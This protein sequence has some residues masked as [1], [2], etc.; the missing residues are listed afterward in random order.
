MAD[1]L[2][3]AIVVRE[4]RQTTLLPRRS[5]RAETEQFKAT[6][7]R[8]KA[9]GHWQCWICGRTD[10]LQVHH[11]LIQRA[12]WPALDPEKV[13]TVTEIIDLYGY[14]KMLTGVPIDNPDVIRLMC[15]LCPAHHAGDQSDGAANGVH[16]IEF[17]AW[18]MQRLVRPGMDLI[19][20]D[21]ESAQHQLAD[22]STTQEG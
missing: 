18:I 9:D 4:L 10:R 22:I 17:G 2:P 14:G 13:R 11:F 3:P 5:R 12:A 6:K 7:A 15:V 1:E 8:L 16:N 19:P 21:G 20:Q